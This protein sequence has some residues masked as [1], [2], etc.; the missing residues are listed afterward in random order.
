[1]KHSDYFRAALSGSFR[2]ANEGVIVLEGEDVK[3][4]ANFHTWLYT[5]KLVNVGGDDAWFTLGD[6]AH[7]YRLADRYIVP[8][9]K[10]A[11]ID[12]I[13]AGRVKENEYPFLLAVNLYKQLP[14]SDPMCKLLVDMFAWDESTVVKKRISTM[15]D[16]FSSA[17]LE[18]LVV[19]MAERP[20]PYKVYAAPWKTSVCASYHTHLDKSKCGR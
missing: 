4:F 17:F 16:R 13:I 15:S 1:M 5:S 8:G 19:A 3:A 12:R 20:N 2:E 18:N 7:L 9:L 10:N 11:I 6:I 14:S